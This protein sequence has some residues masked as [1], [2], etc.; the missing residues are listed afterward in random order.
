MR[1]LQI[2]VYTGAYTP[3][4]MIPH[5]TVFLAFVLR[6]LLTR[7]VVYWHL[8]FHFALMIPLQNVIYHQRGVTMQLFLGSLPII[9][10]LFSNAK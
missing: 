9:L 7:T 1:S 5:R 3:E 2:Q 4:F 8:Y 6:S 10:K